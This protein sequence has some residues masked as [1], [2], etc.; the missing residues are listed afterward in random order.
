MNTQKRPLLLSSALTLSTIGSS[1]ATISYLGTFIFYKQALPYIEKFT[2]TLTPELISRFY[3]LALAVICLV[4]LLGVVK[5]WKSQKAGFFIYLIA[6]LCLFA[7]PLLYIGSHAFSSTNAIFTLLFVT[8]YGVF[9]KSF[10][11]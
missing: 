9:Y 8:I 6:Q 3:I 4:S 1:I 2:N 7:L 5:M 11:Q 10:R